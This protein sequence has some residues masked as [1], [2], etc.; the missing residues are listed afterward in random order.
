MASAGTNDVSV[1]LADVSRA[2]LE[3]VDAFF[4]ADDLVSMCEPSWNAVFER[5][6]ARSFP[7]RHS[8]VALQGCELAAD[9]AQAS[10]VVRA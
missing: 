6:L 3:F 5:N 4:A 8:T 7:G 2:T 9:K 1:A 10:V